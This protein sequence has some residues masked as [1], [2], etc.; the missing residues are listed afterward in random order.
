MTYDQAQS[1]RLG[2]R[3]PVE[4]ISVRMFSGG[5]VP[6]AAWPGQL[7]YINEEQ[8]LQVYNGSAWEDVTGGDLGQLTFVGSTV[9][10][11]QNIGDVWFNTSDNN[12]MHVA[13]SVGA[14]QIATGEWEVI[15]GGV[16]P[17]T[18]TTHIYRQD[19][20]P[21]AATSS[22]VPKENDF[23]YETPINK[24]YYYMATAPGNHWVAVRDTGIDIAINTSI[25][26]YSVSA[27]ETI[28]P[29]TGWSTATPT[30]APGTFIWVRT[31]TTRNDGTTSTTSPALMT[32]NTGVQGSQGIPGPQ[33][34]NGQQLYTWLKYADTPNTGM[35]DDPAGKAYLGLSYNQ[36]NPTESSNYADYS[37]SLTAGTQGVQGPPG[38][39]GQPTYT[40]IKYGTSMTG[41]GIN[42]SSV[43]MTHIG[44]AYNRTTPTESTDPLLYEWSLIQGPQGVPGAP[45]ATVT[46]TAT[47]QVLAVPAAGGATTPATTTVTGVP[48]NTTITAWTYS[49]D[50]AAFSATVPAG[51]SRA[52][53][54]VTITGSTMTA[55]TIAVKMATVRVSA[56]PAAGGSGPAGADAYT[57]ILTNEAHAFPGSTTAA[58]AGSTTTQVIAY[59]GAT[60]SNATIG[61]VTGQ[62]TGLTTAITNNS[63]TT[64]TLTITVTTALT[65]GG[66]LTIPI[67]VD[68]KSFTKTFSW[69]LSLAGAQGSQ[70]NQGT[71]GVSLTLVTPYFALVT[72]GAAAPTKPTQATPIAPWVNAEPAY[73][74]NTELYRT[75]KNLFSDTTFSYTNVSKVSSYTAA[76]AKA[77]NFYASTPPTS[78]SVGD[79]WFNTADDNH[80]Y[81]ASMIG[82]TAIAVPPANGWWDIKDPNI[83]MINPLNAEV[84]AN[85]GGIEDLNTSV[86]SNAAAANT[87]QNAAETA[88]GRVSM[89]DYEPGK[90]DVEGRNPGSIWFTRTR[91][92]FNLCTNPSFELNTTDW[93]A[94]SL[95]AVRTAGSD[96][97]G[98]AGYVARLTNNTSAAAHYYSAYFGPASLR[99]P[100]A[101]GQTYTGST[102]ARHVSGLNTGIYA[103]IYWYDAAGVN[104]ASALGTAVDLAPAAGEV[105]AWK[106]LRVTGTAPA[107]A[108]SFFYRLLAPAANINDVWEVD[109]TLIE[110][111]DDMGRYFDGGSFDGSWDD[112]TKPSN[113]TSTLEGGK[114]LRVY[115]LQEEDWNR[116]YFTEDTIAGLDAQKLTGSLDGLLL[117]DN[118]VAPDKMYS[119]QVVASEALQPGDLVNV[120]NSTGNF[121]VRKA[122]ALLG[123]E[124]H[125]FVLDAAPNG[126]YVNVLHTGYNTFMVNSVPGVQFLGAAGKVTAQPPW[127]VGQ[128]VQRVGFAPTASV[129]NFSPMQPVKII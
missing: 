75:E 54:V 103:R 6:E 56:T 31:T 33:G 13:K 126:S 18:A 128:L 11:S 21:T 72:T 68:G 62:V 32:G 88:D 20:P 43:G 80:P 46:I 39:N 89:S 91:N 24:Q 50:G 117:A 64:A 26:E 40:W 109:A 59:K 123:Y 55:K 106:R 127:A 100:C 49:V 101:E 108:V 60:L 110:Q 116:K 115:E 107:L 30:R 57:V 44:I 70:G 81:Y 95:T 42:D 63:T 118:T 122:D 73:L 96:A 37:W 22:P 10:V 85:R 105:I 74:A 77:R 92:R 113:T 129:L 25:T 82:A 90:D 98:V 67:T 23:W 17:I 94:G 83:D 5:E 93:S 84:E 47:S 102:Y 86:E 45:A 27:S 104:F 53:N 66:T 1:P 125:G 14:D 48:V 16:P 87:A 97:F 19:N 61:T 114:I 28:A 79:T 29:T 112:S 120:W 99:Q 71:A 78:L 35:S 7:I 111:D 65:T 12:R 36:T 119:Y 51:V 34:P 52:G 124:A 4:S 3:A 76:N 38:P 58:L 2:Q 8:I 41:A 9:P 15:S 121:R 69:T